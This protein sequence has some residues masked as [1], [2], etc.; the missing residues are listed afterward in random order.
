MNAK[1]LAVR[2]NMAELSKHAP[3]PEENVHFYSPPP[4]EY[5]FCPS[6]LRVDLK[7]AA[8]EDMARFW[9]VQDSNSRPRPES[10]S[11]YQNTTKQ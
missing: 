10:G 6:S 5:Y 4:L 9:G 2:Q 11:A 3:L 1:V 7:N 8:V